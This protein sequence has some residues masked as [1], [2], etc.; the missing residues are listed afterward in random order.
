MTTPETIDI[1]MRDP[2]A[3]SEQEAPASPSYAAV[4]A[5]SSY[6]S[7]HADASVIARKVLQRS[8]RNIQH[9]MAEALVLEEN[10]APQ[11]E[12]KKNQEQLAAATKRAKI[13]KDAYSII[14]DAPRDKVRVPM[15]DLPIFQLK[16]TFTISRKRFLI[17]YQTS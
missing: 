10:I 11:T 13:I 4:T 9:L 1:A 12:I 14:A 7:A 3:V 16:T 8:K 6:H 2:A 15:T 5:S 17:L